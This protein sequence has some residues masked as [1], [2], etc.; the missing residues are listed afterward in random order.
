MTIF[1]SYAQDKEQ[2]L[3]EAYLN[4]AA[5]VDSGCGPDFADTQVK[6]GS[7]GSASSEAARSKL[8]FSVYIMAAVAMLGVL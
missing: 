8:G 1:A 2:P 5:Q 4:C 3:S 7:V 6:V